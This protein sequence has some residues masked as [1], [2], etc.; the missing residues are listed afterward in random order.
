LACV[1]CNIEFEADFCP[2][3]GEKKSVDRITFQ[4]ILESVFSSFIDMDKGLLFNLK[5]LTL[6]PKKTILQ[7]IKGK[8]R[9]V[10]NPIS[11]AIITISIYIFIDSILPKGSKIELPKED[12]FGSI[13]VGTKTGLFLKNKMKFFWLTFPI[14]NAF[15]TRIF[16]KKFN[17]FEHLAINCFIVGHATL[18]AILTRLIYNKEFIIFNIFVFIYISILHYIVFKNPKDKF[19]TGAMSFLIFILSYLFFMGIP[20]VIANFFT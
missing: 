11:Y 7:Y 4:S 13:K 19:G 15:F 18:L 6:Y 5:N 10:L 3:C 9:Q 17:Y 14:Y 8:R 20:I 1:N 2:K 12:V 16:F